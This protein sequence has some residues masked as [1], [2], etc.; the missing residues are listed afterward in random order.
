[1][2]EKQPPALIERGE[3]LLPEWLE[4]AVHKRREFQKGNVHNVGSLKMVQPYLPI[5]VWLEEL[6][7]PVHIEGDIQQHL[8]QVDVA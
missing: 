7:H 3:V 4:L 6:K 1:M 2:K 8:L 5:V